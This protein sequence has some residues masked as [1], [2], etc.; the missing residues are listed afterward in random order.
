MVRNN[1]H[2]NRTTIQGRDVEPNVIN[3]IRSHEHSTCSI[4]IF[5][6]QINEEFVSGNVS[7]AL[8]ESKPDELV[9]VTKRSSSG[10]KPGI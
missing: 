6:A 4:Y 7:I 5:D 10:T 1:L 9:R 2:A 3:E 8:I